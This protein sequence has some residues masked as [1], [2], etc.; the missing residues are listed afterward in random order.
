MWPR[1]KEWPQGALGHRYLK[2]SLPTQGERGLLVFIVGI[3]CLT[4][5]TVTAMA[6]ANF[7]ESV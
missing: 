5:K 7:L 6:G 3:Q 4:V 1:F 2:G